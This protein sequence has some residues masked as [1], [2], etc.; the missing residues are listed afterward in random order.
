MLNV[1]ESKLELFSFFEQTPDLVCIAGK[2]GYFKKIN[3]AVI[4]KL[5]YS[6]EELFASPISSF[7]YHEDKG[8]THD[9][10]Q[11][12]LSGKVLHNF[13]NRYVTKSGE[14]IWLDWTSIYFTDDEVVFALAKDITQN[15]KTE[16]EAEEKYTK[17]KS[18]ATHFKSS[19]EKDRKYFAYE[20]HEE[21]AQLAAAIKLDIDWIKANTP[22]LPEY[23]KS[24]IENVA[25]VSALL[26]N[27]IKKISFSVSPNMLDFFGLND[28]LEWLCHDFNILNSI[29]CEFEKTYDEASLSQ[30]I[31]IDFFR[32]CQEALKNIVD[33]SDAKNVKIIIEDIGS[34]IRLSIIDDGKGFE[35]DDQKQTFGFTSMHGRAASINGQLKIESTP[36]EGTKIYFTVLKTT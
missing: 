22:E 11:E 13:I 16:I 8:V 5:G 4:K 21:L 29:K 19:I 18:L 1:K 24:R 9:N 2:D 10:R 17:F 36:G 35:M 31:K 20:L 30:E 25:D 26:I 3:P 32:I 7:I 28:T 34:R 23:S 27:K 12:L 14:I 6:Q 33:H 15:K